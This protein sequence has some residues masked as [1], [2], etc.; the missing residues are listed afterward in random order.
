MST[1]ITKGIN[2]T[3][4]GTSGA[5]TLVGATLNIPQYGGG[6]SA[7]P[8]VI[9]MSV[10]DGSPVTGTTVDTIS[11]ILLIPANTFTNNG[12]LEIITRG[13]RNV[14]GA[15]AVTFRVY[16]NTSAS[17]TGATLIATSGTSGTGLAFNQIIRTTRINSN[18]LTCLNSALTASTDYATSASITSVTFNTSVDNYLLFSCQLVNASDTAY[19]EIA[20]A[21]KYI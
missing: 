13:T 19:N 16:T 10:T 12:I 14:V 8:S 6:S 2:L 18:I 5:A 20:R 7:N 17:L 9:A 15:A 21:V 3:T 4:T 11:R 1:T